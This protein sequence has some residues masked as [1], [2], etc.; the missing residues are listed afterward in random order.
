MGDYFLI[1]YGI[2]APLFPSNKS[3]LYG[4][5]DQT[6]HFQVLGGCESFTAI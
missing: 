6:V 4:L 3:N 5:A 2:K 1:V